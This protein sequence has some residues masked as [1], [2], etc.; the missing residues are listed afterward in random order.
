[1]NLDHRTIS[2]N[3]I[4]LA[5][6]L[7]VLFGII[8]WQLYGLDP[9]AYCDIVQ[10][11]GVPPGD[12]C[13]QLLKDGLRIKGWTIWLLIGTVALFVIIVLVAAVKVFFSLSGPGGWN[14]DINAKDGPDAK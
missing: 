5:L 12:H 13:F 6:V 2:W 14:L 9:K 11:Q 3:I 4:A 10:N 8:I 1:M 7:P